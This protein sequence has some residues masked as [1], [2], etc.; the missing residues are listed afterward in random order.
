MPHGHVPLGTCMSRALGL[1]G[2]TQRAARQNTQ[3]CVLTQQCTCPP[4]HCV[5]SMRQGA[6]TIPSLWALRNGVQG[7]E[8]LPRL[9]S[10]PATANHHH[11]R[12][13]FPA[14]RQLPAPEPH[15]HVTRFVQLNGQ[16]RP[17]MNWCDDLLPPSF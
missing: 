1:S 10:L 11:T 3:P 12:S 6:P 9:P 2:A 16:V 17:M 15:R 5:Q 14:A 4:Y 7:P 8:R 13:P